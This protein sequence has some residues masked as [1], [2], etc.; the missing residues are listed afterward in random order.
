[1]YV[2]MCVWEGGGGGI[3]VQPATK[4]EV[5]DMGA[6]L[7]CNRGGR[8]FKE[9]LTRTFFRREGGWW[10]GGGGSIV[11]RISFTAAPP[12]PTLWGYMGG[13]CAG[14]RDGQPVCFVVEEVPSCWF[15]SQDFLLSILDGLEEADL[16]SCS[17]DMLNMEKPT[18]RKDMSSADL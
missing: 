15:L 5:W 12:A 1:M 17:C 2:C 7:H 9:L 14:H 4:A 10:W 8:I 13:E 16:V 11:S 6:A 18:P 3:C